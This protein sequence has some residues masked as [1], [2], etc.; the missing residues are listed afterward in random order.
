MTA[1]QRLRL[2][3]RPSALARW[4]ADWVAQRLIG[5]GV[6]V[7]LV[8]I[9][10]QGDVARDRIGNIGSPGVFTKEL[11]NALLEKRID[12]AV[13]SLKDLPTEPVAALTLAAIPPR[14][15]PYD[16][17]VSRGTLLADLPQG[18]TIGTDSLRRRAQLLFAR[19]DLCMKDIRGNVDTRIRKLEEGQYDALV[20]AEAGLARLGL[21]QHISQVLT[22]E[23][24]LPAVGQGALAIEARADDEATLAAV[25]SL[26]D[27]RTRQ[28]VIAERALLAA[29][30]GGCLAPIGALGQIQSDGLLHLRAIVLSP[31][32]RSR[33][34]ASA[35]DEPADA[36][37]LG[38]HVA[39]QLILQGAEL[40]IDAARRTLD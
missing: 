26:D 22:V 29:L 3:T 35:A 6:D 16:V 40:L 37:Q 31:D 2:G 7:E 14:D 34:T 30:R 39:D 36:I 12:L 24:M 18:A 8:P 28:A 5:L 13:H 11:Q 10:T 23:I 21:Q 1:S 19:S 27:P 32:G 17:L 25:A 33:L 38:G 15:S 20:L 9:T 4:Q